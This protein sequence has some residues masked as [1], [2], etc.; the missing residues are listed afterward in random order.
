MQTHGQM[1]TPGADATTVV[2]GVDGAGRS[3]R[4]RDLAA[5]LDRPVRWVTLPSS[6][7]DLDLV[8]TDARAADAVVIVDDAHHGQPSSWRALAAAARAGQAMLIARRPV[9]RAVELADL[10]Q[11]VAAAGTVDQLG[12]LDAAGVAAVV[13]GAG[14]TEPDED[15]IEEIRTASGGMAAV[16]ASL[17]TATSRGSV[18]TA[19]SR[20]SVATATSR[21]LVPAALRAR[22][23]R[24]LAGLPA[25]S[26][27]VTQ[28]LAL[29]LDVPDSVVARAA[30]VTVATVADTSNVLQERGMIAPGSASLIPAVAA[31][32][33]TDLPVVVRRQ[34]HDRVATALLDSGTDPLLAAVQL[35]RARVRTPTAAVAYAGA[36][37]HLRF[38]DPDAAVSWY[39]AA[40]EAGAQPAAV[41]LGR[42]E[43]A[44]QLGTPVDLTD[45]SGE[46]ARLAIVVAA[47]AA[48]QGRWDRA[49]EALADA[50][51]PGAA[52]AAVAWAATGHPERAGDAARRARTEP[53]GGT[54]EALARL[55]EAAAGLAEP[56]AMLPLLI[57]SAEAAQR[58][59]P[60]VVLPDSPHALGA[61][62]AGLTGDVSTAERLLLAGLAAGVGGPVTARRHQLLLAFTRMRA[63]RYDTAAAELAPGPDPT[64]WDHPTARD[65][66]LAAALAAGMARRSGDVARMR[67]AWNGVETQLARR[68]VDLFAIEVLEELVVTAARLRRMVR[69]RPVM[70][71]LDDLVA[72]A[73]DPPTWVVA[74]GWIRVQVAVALEDAATAATLAGELATAATLAGP[75]QRAQGAAALAWADVLAGKVDVDR[76]CSVAGDLAT[77]QLPWDAS[78]LVGQAAIRTTDATAARRLLEHARGL[79]AAE[80]GGGEQR[81]RAG[82]LSEREIAV[83]RMVLEGRTQREIGSQLYLSP[84]TVEHHVA[85]MRTK[86]DASSRAEFLAALR[87]HPG[88]VD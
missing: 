27:A 10:D 13:T 85:R 19:T 51:G 36:A 55:A 78:R 17:A 38:R 75:R 6:D 24:R 3:R 31:A 71:V 82:V 73:G 81:G 1:T 4:L 80:V 44:T 52:L 86:L 32:I 45:V 74:V 58:T 35:R 8:L 50:D 79:S 22:V 29:L 67:E 14:V 21:G 39:D 47:I 25:D 12:P 11:V 66:L 42:A 84:K 5:A 41:D 57:E 56:E 26:A 69:A 61:L 46:P 60:D 33:R 37:D 15:T 68:A 49:A 53:S 87:E 77:N 40:V 9:V 7:A 62:V 54:P 76:V 48:Q 72:R 88:V 18:A 23:Q 59:P 16:A 43:A 28:V 65:Q 30:G 20:G 70:D 34:L 83:G 64:A 2:V 63:G